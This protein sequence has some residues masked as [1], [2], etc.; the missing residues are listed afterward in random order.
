MRMTGNLHSQQN[1][2]REETSSKPILGLPLS[3]ISFA[4]SQQ[5]HASP[6][7]PTRLLLPLT[8]LLAC[9]SRLSPSPRYRSTSSRRP[10]KKNLTLS[11]SRSPPSLSS[12][13]P[14]TRLTARKPVSSE[15]TRSSTLS[16]S[17]LSSPLLEPSRR[18]LL[19]RFRFVLLRCSLFSRPVSYQTLLDYQGSA[20]A[21]WRLW[22]RLP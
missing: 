12:P 15:S 2:R 8:H 1:Q 21:C 7:P 9:P 17:D 10:I 11:C 18:L 19:S 13:F 22:S 4:S 6:L 3:E 14:L 20:E 5:P 16:D